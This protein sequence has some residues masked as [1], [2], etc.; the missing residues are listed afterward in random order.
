MR[1]GRRE[2]D[3]AGRREGDEAREEGGCIYLCRLTCAV[4]V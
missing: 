3:G 4:A 2:G 1:Q